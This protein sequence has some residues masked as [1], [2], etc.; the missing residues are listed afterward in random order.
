MKCKY[1]GLFFYSFFFLVFVCVDA[2]A[3][4]TSNDKRY[5]HLRAEYRELTINDPFVSDVIL[6]R[7]LRAKLIEL[8]NHTEGQKIQAPILY[9]KGRVA[10]QLGRKLSDS[11]VLQEAQKDFLRV[12]NNY[13]DSELADDALLGL[14]RLA[15]NGRNEAEKIKYAKLLLEYY[16]TSDSAEHAKRLLEQ[17]APMV[18]E[19]QEHDGEVSDLLSKYP[20]VAI[21]PGHGGAEEG[22]KGPGDIL[23]KD[24]VLRISHL[25]SELLQKDRRLRVVM[26]RK[27]DETVSLAERTRIANEA[28][29]ELFL[30]IHANASEYKTGR[31]VETYYLDN[32]DEKSSLKLAERENFTSIGETDSVG[33]IVSD[34]IQGIKLDDS[35]SL[36]HLVQDGVYGSLSTSFDSIRNLKVKKAPFFVLVGAHMPCAL[37]EVSFIDH[38]IEGRRLADPRYQRLIA[39]GIFEGIRGYLL[40]KDRLGH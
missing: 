25:L 8:S 5:S 16:P 22:A 3:E 32:T 39:E 27:G 18:T 2:S 34:F 38:P 20:V 17:T 37:V 30:S 15:D 4:E 11:F 12:Y 23:E 21:D 28:N 35:I 6:W 24:I 31:G 33:F 36:A 14:T 40:K 9:L 13:S 29:A 10:E 7:E 26:T 19:V 1:L